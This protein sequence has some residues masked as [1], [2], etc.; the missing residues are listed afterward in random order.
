MTAQRVA[1]ALIGALL[2]LFL[3]L[4]IVSL[5]ASAS[6]TDVASGLRHPL[7]W[8]ALRLS[9]TTTLITLAIVVTLG[10]P[11]SWTL[12]RRQGRFWQALESAIQLPVV[13]PPAVAGVALLLAFGR[14]GLFGAVLGGAGWSVTFTTTAVVMAEVF[15]SA[16]F[17]VQAATSAFRRIDPQLVLVSRTFGASPL[18]VFFRVA[19]PL[20]APGLGAAAAMAWARALGEFGATLMF[21]GNLPGTTQTLPLAI[22]TALEADLRAAQAISMALVVVAFSLLWFV[23][24]TLKSSLEVS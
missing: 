17:F 16:P 11:L 4:P 3:A 10:T 8:P 20:A 18:R 2:V 21:A 12:S 13:I 7:V 19:V 1:L 24:V 22:Y 9:L 23:R 15:V 5:F 14:R 6:A